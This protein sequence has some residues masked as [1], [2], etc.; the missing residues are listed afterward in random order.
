MGL[1]P[2]VKRTSRRAQ[3]RVGEIG[4]SAGPAGDQPSRFRT[5]PGVGP[6]S[7]RLVES[8]SWRARGRAGEKTT[9]IA[10][11]RSIPF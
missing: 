9:Q 4:Q 10:V 2:W 1:N 3:G 11:T 5:P 8:A 6:R 7:R